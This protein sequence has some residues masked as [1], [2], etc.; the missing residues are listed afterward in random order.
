MKTLKTKH[1]DNIDCFI[2]SASPIFLGFLG[3][4]ACFRC[5]GCGIEYQIN[6]EALTDEIAEMLEKL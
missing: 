1:I 5:R 3:N 2:C 4:K 6:R